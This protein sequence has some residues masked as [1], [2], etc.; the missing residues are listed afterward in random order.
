MTVCHV[1]QMKAEQAARQRQEDKRIIAFMT[2]HDHAASE[3]EATL[4]EEARAELVGHYQKLFRE[5]ELKRMRAEWRVARLELINKR[6]RMMKEDGEMWDREMQGQQ[7]EEGQGR[8]KTWLESDDGHREHHGR[9]TW[10]ESLLESPSVI[11]REETTELITPDLTVHISTDQL[12]QVDCNEHTTAEQ[13]DATDHA[14]A[15][16]Q[17]EVDPTE[18]RAT[19]QPTL[20]D[21]TDHLTTDKLTSTD[22]I[23]HQTTV[24]QS[25]VEPLL[26][27][28]QLMTPA[29]SVIQEILYDRPTTD[30]HLLSRMERITLR[31]PSLKSTRGEATPTVV[32]EILYPR[33][34][35]SE[36]V[37]EEG[38]PRVVTTRG[39]A[40]PSIVQ[41]IMY[42]HCEH[43]SD[44]IQDP[45]HPR[46]LSTR[47]RGPTD[48]AHKLMYPDIKETVDV[49][50]ATETE[51][52]EV[53]FDF[54]PSSQ[55]QDHFEVFNTTPTGDLLETIVGPRV[56][57]QDNDVESGFLSLYPLPALLENCIA[58][59][60]ST[61]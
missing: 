11:K 32:N 49:T 56:V 35:P 19:D 30:P 25:S 50:V 60:L 31:S 14:T 28:I 34:I 20:V 22:S 15:N 37:E 18:H 39:T 58:L 43:G 26:T 8:R 40:P 10:L 44:M 29:P 53:I 51:R 13:L 48:S 7:I 57:S 17:A 1:L 46:L 47:G 36:P 9:K 38:L 16:Q 55:F 33:G 6:Q 61:Q 21:V 54:G 5:A 3:R 23:D 2:E 52:D 12:T 41:N 45:L 27:T 24:K 42:V 59:P 4:K